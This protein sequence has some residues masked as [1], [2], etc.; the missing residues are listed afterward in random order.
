MMEAESKTLQNNKISQ[1]ILRIDLMPGDI[2]DFQWLAEQ[3]SQEYGTTRTELHVNY[4]VDMNTVEVD[5]QKF[6]TYILEKS[7]DVVLRLNCF[8]RSIILTSNKYKDNSIY[9]DRLSRIVKLLTVKHP[10]LAASR[11]GMRYINK[12][13]CSKPADIG[14][15]L[16]T[17]DANNIKSSLKREDISRTMLV[18]EYQ[19]GDF[20]TRIQCGIPNKF[21]PSVITNYELVLDIDVYGVGAQPITRWE[22]SVRDYNHGAYL[23]FTKYVNPTIMESLR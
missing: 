17:S 15:Y 8:E 12:F 23:Y 20:Q 19:H 2:I 22:E 14:K 6:L 3:L 1:F 5:K 16:N 11:I 13:P 18:H 10:D 21:Y 9:K 4:N 7:P